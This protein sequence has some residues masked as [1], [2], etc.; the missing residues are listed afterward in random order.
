M[1]YTRYNT[2]NMITINFPKLSP[3]Q[4]LALPRTLFSC[5]QYQHKT[6]GKKIS[7]LMVFNKKI[8]SI[9]QDS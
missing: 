7:S 6:A 2:M 3:N 1:N 9:P 8:I 5:L 4:Y